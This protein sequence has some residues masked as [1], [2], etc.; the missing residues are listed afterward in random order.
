[1]DSFTSLKGLSYWLGNPAVGNFFFLIF[2]NPNSILR[3]LKTLKIVFL[4][5][6]CDAVVRQSFL[7]G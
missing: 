1:M 7:L 3:N 6:F 2:I 4:L 5:Q